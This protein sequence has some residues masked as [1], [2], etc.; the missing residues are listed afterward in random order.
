MRSLEG[1][2]KDL[3]KGDVVKARYDCDRAQYS[4]CRVRYDGEIATEVDALSIDGFFI[5][6]PRIEIQL[7]LGNVFQIQ[8]D[9]G[10]K[11][12]QNIILVRED[13]RQLCNDVCAS[14][15]YGFYNENPD[16]YEGI[17]MLDSKL[18]DD[19]TPV[20]IQKRMQNVRNIC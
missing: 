1:V 6:L 3:I 8:Y 5:S 7:R 19:A 13:N 14:S 2:L 20:Q 10:R 18:Q 15:L 12:Y 4:G 17:T 16:L 11:V 9:L